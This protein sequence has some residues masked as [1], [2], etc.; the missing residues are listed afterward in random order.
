M[1]PK[2]GRFISS[3]MT[4]NALLA[5]TITQA[6][7]FPKY[8][9]VVERE[10]LQKRPIFDADNRYLLVWSGAVKSVALAAQEK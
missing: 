10:K 5:I 3:E 8:E 2:E 4:G 7:T 1:L 9:V 6:T